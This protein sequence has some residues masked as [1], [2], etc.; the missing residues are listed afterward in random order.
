[1]IARDTSLHGAAVTDIGRT[2][3][4]TRGLTKIY[5]QGAAQVHALLAEVDREDLVE[6]AEREALGEVEEPDPEQL[7]LEQR[8]RVRRRHRIG[9]AV[10]HHAGIVRVAP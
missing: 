3:F 8:R 7:A 6:D 4:A 1:M 10:L 2:V 5:G 9:T